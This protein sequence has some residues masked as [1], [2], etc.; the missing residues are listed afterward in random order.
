MLAIEAS[1]PTILAGKEWPKNARTQQAIAEWCLKHKRLPAT[2]ARF[3]ASA[4]AAEPSLTHDPEASN[5]VYAACAAALAGCGAGLDAGE[6]DS[7]Q[8]AE[9]RRQALEWLTA[10]YDVWA[11]RHTSEKPGERT[12]AAMAVRD[13]LK[14][15]VVTRWDRLSSSWLDERAQLSADL[16]CVRDEQALAKL[17]A[18]ERQNWQKLWEKVAVLAASD[19]SALI[20]QARAHAARTQ[21]E[22]AVKCYAE[23]VALEPTESADIWFEYAA[24]QLL[25]KDRAGY[26]GTCAYML[27]RCSPKGPMRPYLVARACTLAPEASVD[28]TRI[29]ELAAT[30][31]SASRVE[32]WSVTEQAALNVRA[33]QY[34]VAVRQAE[35]SLV[36]DG[37]PGRAVLNWLWLSL[38]HQ[39]MDN[40]NEASRWLNKATS[41]L[42]QQDSRMPPD[43]MYLRMHLHNWLEAHVLRQ[44]AEALLR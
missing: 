37:S 1:I 43:H 44:E 4:L 11:Q 21:W 29:V 32:H 15:D 23:A 27:A 38:A 28:P 40:R 35:T 24:A 2:A 22:E 34:K 16:A 17:P 19:P 8:R 26:R 31:L 9:L 42:D 36:L 10:E 6:L 18:E 41:W 30:E 20:A 3:Y 33:K 25:A 5:R 14:I 7:R 13:W 12:V 39:K